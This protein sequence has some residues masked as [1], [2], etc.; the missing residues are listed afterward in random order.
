MLPAKHLAQM[1]LIAVNNR[2]RQPDRRLVCTAP[3]YH[4]KEGKTLQSRAHKH[5]AQHD[6]RPD[7]RFWVWLRRWNIGSLSGKGEEVCDELRKK[8]IDVCCLEVR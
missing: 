3:A 6:G 1:I 2:G 4:R 8:R 7:G 5:S